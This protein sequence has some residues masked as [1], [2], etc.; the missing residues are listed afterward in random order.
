MTYYIEIMSSWCTYVE[1]G[2]DELQ[3]RYTGRVN[4]D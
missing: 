2:W 4:F 3:K 1:P